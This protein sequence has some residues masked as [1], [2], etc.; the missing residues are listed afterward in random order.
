MIKIVL[1][2]HRRADLTVEEFRRQWHGQH[3]ELL[4]RLPG[5]QRLVLN[6]VLPGPDGAPPPCDGIAED[7]FDSP[8]AMQAAFA[9]PEGQAVAADAANFLDLA[10]LQMLAVSEHDVPLP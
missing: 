2:L 9:S 8:E 5:L 6:D 10:R 4:S 1:L 7:W 3:T